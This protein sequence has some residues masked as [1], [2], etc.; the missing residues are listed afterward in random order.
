[1]SPWTEREVARKLAERDD[2]E[3]PEGLLEKIKSEIPPVVNV[4]PRAVGDNVRVFPTVQVSR[5]PR[6]RRWLIAASL[7]A[8]VGGGL[9]ALQVMKTTPQPELAAVREPVR[10]DQEMRPAS[11]PPP[12]AAAPS[13]Q[14]VPDS[15]PAAPK[16]MPQGTRRD[17]RGACRTRRQWPPPTR[18][19]GPGGPAGR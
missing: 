4:G 16:V 17:P 18:R 9:V 1:M 5:E 2:I 3:P 14:A 6:H 19:S 10:Q 11:P 15:A 7:V 8:T 13:P 12:A